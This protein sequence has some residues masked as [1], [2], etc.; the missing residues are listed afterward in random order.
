[1]EH[2]AE[3]EKLVSQGSYYDELL[4]LGHVVARVADTKAWRDEI[5]A[6]ARADKIKVRTG[7]SSQDED[8]PGRGQ[9]LGRFAPAPFV[10][11]PRIGRRL[12]VAMSS[13][14]TTSV[15]ASIHRPQARART[16]CRSS[17]PRALGVQVLEKLVRG[18]FDVLVPPFGGA[19]VAG[20]QSHPVQPA[21]IAVHKRVARLRLVVGAVGQAEVP[22]PS[23]RRS[24]SS[25]RRS[26]R[27]RAAARPPSV[28]AARTGGHRSAASRA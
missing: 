8:V 16:L 18:E 17:T 25:G 12:S 14:A 21:E 20:D 5:R 23:P 6:K 3:D 11:R 22:A 24:A 1:M 26:A 27:G 19:K 10:H 7:V 13:T 9:V 15:R 4:R 28:S 2:E